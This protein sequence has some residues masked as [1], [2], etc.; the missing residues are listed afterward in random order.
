[1]VH[2]ILLDG[3]VGIAVQLGEKPHFGWSNLC[4]KFE[5]SNPST[6]GRE[7]AKEVAITWIGNCTDYFN[8]QSHESMHISI[9]AR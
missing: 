3:N 1:L 6:P 7:I 8:H 9:M 2:H 4:I 5:S